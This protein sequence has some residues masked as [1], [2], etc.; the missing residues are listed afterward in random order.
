VSKL[1]RS[2]RFWIAVVNIGVI[3]AGQYG[4]SQAVVSRWT[5]ISM[6]LIGAFTVADAGTSI[7]GGNNQP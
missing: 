6:M 3:I 1:L 2:K 5:E 7:I 4:V